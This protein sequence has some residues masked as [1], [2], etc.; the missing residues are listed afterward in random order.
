MQAMA[1]ETQSTSSPPG[2]RALTVAELAQ[3]LGARLIGDGDALV[4]GVKQDSRRV[5]PGELFVAL[6]GAHVDG[7]GFAEAAM[8]KGACAVMVAGDAVPPID[9]PVLLVDDARAA[10]AHAAAEVYLRP[11]DAMT[12]VGI[13]GTNGKTTVA[14]MIEHALT[15][16]RA[17]PGI[18]G[19]L[20]HRFEQHRGSLIHTSPEADELQRIAADMLAR[21][22]THLVMEVSSIA[23]MASRVAHVSFDVGVFTNL[24]QD[25]LDW[26]GTMEAYAEAKARLFIEHA[27]AL[28][29]I[30]VDDR[31][32][33]ELAARIEDEGVGRVVRVSLDPTIGTG[34]DHVGIALPP[35]FTE[36]GLEV[37]VSVGG[38]TFE[39]SAPL[40][41]MHNVSNLLCALAVV[42]GLELDVARAARALESLPQVPGRLER[43]SD[44]ADDIVA[45]VDYAHTPDALRTVLQSLRPLPDGS[46]LWCVFGCGGDRDATKRRAMGQAA[47][48]G[49][50]VVVVTNDNPRSEDPN[51]IADAIVAGLVQ[52]QATGWSVVL[53]RREAIGHVV[54]EASPG[55]VVVVAGKG[56]EPYQIIGDRTFD[57]DDRVE[58]YRAL[59]QRRGGG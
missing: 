11:T 42:H 30:N 33:V 57:L 23:L 56:H 26:H 16:C 3:L 7:V 48:R 15:G 44:A 40:Y 1:R 34:P 18:V 49:A 59:R 5:C 24:T 6:A 32:G 54:R 45:L 28:S 36:I 58:L 50:D 27:P 41:G 17:R 22:A 12:V 43:C 8:A 4:R 37:A 46:R 51:H 13:T 38:H 19:T 53:D 31:F 35:C 55:D 20:G 39:L 52:D 47:A 25:H 29:V 21:G 2:R 10:M 14:H 9:A